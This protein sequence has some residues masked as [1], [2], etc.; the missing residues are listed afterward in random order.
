[1]SS[2]IEYLQVT[3]KAVRPKLAKLIYEFEYEMGPRAKEHIAGI[4]VS[5]GDYLILKYGLD[6]RMQRF[7]D[8]GKWGKGEILKLAK[9]EFMGVP[10]VVGTV[11]EPMILTDG[12]FATRM[13]EKQRKL[14]EHECDS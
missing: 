13:V 7:L 4:A 6:E 2:L 8:K 10:I 11:I 12:E 14:I 3:A 9:V 5:P 1:M